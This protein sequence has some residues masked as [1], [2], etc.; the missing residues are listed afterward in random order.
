MER[1]LKSQSL[2]SN[3]LSLS[4]AETIQETIRADT[5]N[6]TK[7]VKK[8]GNLLQQDHHDKIWVVISIL[9]RGKELAKSLQKIDRSTT[10]I[11]LLIIL[12][13]VIA[14]LGL[15]NLC[16]THCTKNA[17][18]NR[19]NEVEESIIKERKS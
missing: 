14:F 8:M 17:M 13:A 3:I 12:L 16:T 15:V 1:R 9:A 5:I 18:I 4:L 10:Q 11:I 19:L 6:V 2:V 7:L